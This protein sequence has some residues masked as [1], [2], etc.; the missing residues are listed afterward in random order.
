M[1]V[2][3]HKQSEHCGEMLVSTENR[4]GLVSDVEWPPFLRKL[5]K[6][7]PK[8]FRDYFALDRLTLQLEDVT[9]RPDCI[10]GLAQMLLWGTQFPIPYMS[11]KFPCKPHQV[12][13]PGDMSWNLR[14]RVEP[15]AYS[16]S[17]L[18]NA[19]NST[20]YQVNITDYD[21]P[22]KCSGQRDCDCTV[23]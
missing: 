11:F 10:G 12:V 3:H 1:Y 4:P 20:A 16:I 17:P 8:K 9:R 22:C 18:A 7:F 14:Y 19:P 2:Y 5:A 15:D 6:K 21:Y 23:R 13:A